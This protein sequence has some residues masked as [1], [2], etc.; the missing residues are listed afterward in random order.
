MGLATDTIFV[1]HA[2]ISLGKG[3]SS[4]WRHKVLALAKYQELLKD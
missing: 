4:F 3:D 1:A 2:T